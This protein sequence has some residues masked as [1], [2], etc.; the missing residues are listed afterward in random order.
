[1]T[2]LITLPLTA[3][4]APLMA[5]LH[6][7]CFVEPWDER[8]MA[9]LLAMPG[10]GGLLAA[11]GPDQPA[12]FILWRFAA[13]EAEILTLLV[14][15]P[16]RRQGVAGRLLDEALAQASAQGLE[17]FFLEVAA[18]NDAGQALYSS[19]GFVRVGARP[20]YYRN[21]I[22]ALVMKRTL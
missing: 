10:C 15:P 14:L 13:G 5:A 19:R 1:M 8:A 16:Y 9:D 18:D 22:D 6:P 21:C 17:A 2:T 12:G 4:H 11:A 7:I 3:A 20:R